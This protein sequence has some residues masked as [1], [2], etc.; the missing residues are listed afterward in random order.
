M[1]YNRINTSIKHQDKRETT[2]WTTSWSRL[3]PPTSSRSTW[4]TLTGERDPGPHPLICAL[5]SR[6][7]LRWDLTLPPWSQRW[8]VQGQYLVHG[9]PFL[10]FQRN[11][12]LVYGFLSLPRDPLAIVWHWV[13]V[14]R[15]SD[16]RKRS[17]G[18]VH[19]VDTKDLY[20]R[21]GIYTSD[22]SYLFHYIV[23]Q[24]QRRCVI[25]LLLHQH[26]YLVSS[27]DPIQNG[28]DFCPNMRDVNGLS[29]TAQP[30]SYRYSLETVKFKIQS[31]SPIL[32]QVH[33][34]E[35]E[36]ITTLYIF[37]L[38]IYNQQTSIDKKSWRGNAYHFYQPISWLSYDIDCHCNLNTCEG[39]G[40]RE[41]HVPSLSTVSLRSMI[42]ETYSHKEL[43]IEVLWENEKTSCF[44]D[45]MT[46]L[47]LVYRSRSVPLSKLPCRENF[48]QSWRLF[49]YLH[50]QRTPL[51]NFLIST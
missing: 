6:Q 23:S 3:N 16:F 9:P 43:R 11:S 2:P 45:L 10:F 49:L 25:V 51:R 1:T 33:T 37:H 13:L 46:F 5:Y 17:P 38:L 41:V 27:E 34:S 48:S 15:S 28:D 39:K 44:A 31:P 22:G 50:T 21:L 14:W 40:V 29:G 42:Y 36:Y 18:I 7:G 35:I 19:W 12:T 24:W 20:I 4:T 32:S 47:F 30:T 26:S 8:E